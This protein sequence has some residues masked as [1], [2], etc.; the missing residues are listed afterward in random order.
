MCLGHPAGAHL[1]QDDADA[2]IGDLPGRFGTGEA[3]ADDM[4]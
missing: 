4:H 1:V 2:G 3:R